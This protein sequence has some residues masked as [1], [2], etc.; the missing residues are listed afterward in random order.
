M[1][2]VVRELEFIFIVT[3][4]VHQ[5]FKLLENSWRKNVHAEMGEIIANRQFVFFFFQAEDGIRDLT[6]TGVQ[7]CALPI[8]VLLSKYTCVDVAQKVVGVGSV[9][10]RCYVVLLL[11]NDSNDPLIL[12]IKEAQASV[13]EIGRASCR[14]RV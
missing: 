7:T 4:V 10:T 6:V 5:I 11:G 12:Q 1:L 9:G 8:L 3:V 13:L 14:E 2:I